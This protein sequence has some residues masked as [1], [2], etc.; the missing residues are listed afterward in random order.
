MKLTTH[1]SYEV[2][3]MAYEKMTG[4]MAPGKDAPPGMLT[5]PMETRISKWWN[6]NEEHHEVIDAI[7]Y[8]VEE[9]LL[10]EEES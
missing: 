1:Q 7:L 5:E 2:K 4:K 6:W 8:S 10:H 3:A 9:L